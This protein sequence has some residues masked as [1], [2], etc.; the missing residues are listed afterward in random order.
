MR[1]FDV[2]GRIRYLDLFD[3][4]AKPLK[5]AQRLSQDELMADMHAI[6]GTKVFKGF[7]AYQ[8][9]AARIPLL[10]PVCPFLPL[11]FVQAVG[12]RIYRQTA[13]HRACRL[14]PK[15]VVDPVEINSSQRVL[16]FVAVVL[17]AGNVIF[18]SL[19]I[20]SGWPF[21]CYPTF[22][23]IAGDRFRTIDCQI[24]YADGT[25]KIV[26]VQS[27]K[28]FTGA[29]RIVGL[30]TKIFNIKDEPE[31]NRKFLALWDVLAMSDPDL[32]RAQ[33]VR[34]YFLDN[35]TNPAKRQLNPFH[36]TMAFEFNVNR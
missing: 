12:N 36:K 33:T 30:M 35:Y 20:G 18:G 19:G 15:R 27:L 7:A 14:V 11:G 31:R 21:A 1:V 13:D 24:I 4:P 10:W 32:K 26:R 6:I 5:D 22:S 34:F 16:V 23:E 28:A 8:K 25:E 17:I 9:I 29:Y 2:L 3:A